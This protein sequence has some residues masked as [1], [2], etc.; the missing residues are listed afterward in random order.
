MKSEPTSIRVYLQATTQLIATCSRNPVGKDGYL[1]L[2]HFVLKN[3]ANMPAQFGPKVP[4][5]TQKECYRNSFI[6][7]NRYQ[8]ELIYCEGIATT[9]ILP[10]YHAWCINHS[11]QIVDPTWQQKGTEYYGMAIRTAYLVT[12][13][14]SQTHYGLID[15]PMQK[16]P[17]LRA[18][19][20]KWRHPINDKFQEPKLEPKLEPKN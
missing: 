11:G 3:G 13:I 6:M 4:V 8:G 9:G 15:N 18:E 16:W 19:R 14:K 7:A 17:M 2:D 12:S 1:S 5:M 10:V 20:S